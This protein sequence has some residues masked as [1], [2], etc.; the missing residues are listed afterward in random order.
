[1]R[2]SVTVNPAD[3]ILFQVT[4]SDVA[5]LDDVKS[6]LCHLVKFPLEN[7]NAFA[8][9]SIE[10]PR[11]IILTGPPGTGKS[12]LCNA[13]RNEVKTKC[14]DIDTSI[15]V[16]RFVFIHCKTL[17]ERFVICA[18]QQQNYLVS[19]NINTHVCVCMYSTIR[20]QYS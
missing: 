14:F 10:L 12:L 3:A 13:L 1:M 19:G 20:D 2:A 6:L 7:S 15:T 9:K 8:S 17:C 4:F 18:D 11:A 16:D 5:G